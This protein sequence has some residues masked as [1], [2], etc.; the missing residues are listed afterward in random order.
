MQFKGKRYNVELIKWLINCNSFDIID[1]LEECGYYDI[2][3][4]LLNAGLNILDKPVYNHN[5]DN[6]YNDI[7]F[8]ERLAKIRK[9]AKELYSSQ[10]HL[11]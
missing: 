2:S 3:S 1:L 7:A 8:K 9:D 5:I 6:Y 10:K 11:A 4:D